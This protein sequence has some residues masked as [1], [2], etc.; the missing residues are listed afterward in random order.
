M[1]KTVFTIA[2]VAAVFAG[3]SA[4]ASADNGSALAG[5]SIRLGAFMPTQTDTQ[6]AAG[7]TWVGGGVDYKLQGFALPIIPKNGT[8]SLS[9][10]YAGKGS[11][12]TVPL[13]LNWTT[14]GRAYVTFGAGVSFCKFV[15]GNGNSDDRARFAYAG[16][17][18]Y[19]FNTEIPMFIEAKYFGNDQPR[20]AGVGVYLGWRF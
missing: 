17:I 16:G 13:L 10:D 12:S 14:N 5:V 2:A 19:N 20:V 7:S 4:V 15:D 1:K 3:F 18:G 11:F 8:Y 6:N 9:L